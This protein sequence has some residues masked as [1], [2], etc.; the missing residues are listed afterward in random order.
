MFKSITLCRLFN[1][2]SKS[3]IL[4][5]SFRFHVAFH[6]VIDVRGKHFSG[7]HC[8]I[9]FE[10]NLLQGSLKYRYGINIYILFHDIHVKSEPAVANND[11][12]VR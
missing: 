3:S 8:G 11:N 5:L 4:V 6:T 2:I 1:R 12:S 9:A 10:S 7:F